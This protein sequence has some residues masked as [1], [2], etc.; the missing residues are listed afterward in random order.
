MDGKQ[1]IAGSTIRNVARVLDAGSTA[2]EVRER[3][4]LCIPVCNAI[5]NAHQKGIIHRDIKLSNILV[6]GWAREIA[7]DRDRAS[8]KPW[9]RPKPVLGSFPVASTVTTGWSA[10]IVPR[11][12]SGG[13]R[14]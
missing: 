5:Q 3:I 6:A 14:R 13:G 12:V 4:A 9:R 1:V 2:A 7:R 11:L 8:M 10:E